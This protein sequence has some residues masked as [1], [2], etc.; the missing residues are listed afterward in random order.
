VRSGL[1]LFSQITLGSVS[2]WQLA[3]LGLFG[4]LESVFPQ[5]LRRDSEL[6]Y[7]NETYGQRL[8][9]RASV[10]LPDNLK[11]RQLRR[12][13]DTEYREAR[14]PLAH[15]FHI[16]PRYNIST[17]KRNV[18]RFLRL[19]EAARLTLVGFLGMDNTALRRLLPEDA[20]GVPAQNTIDSIGR[21]PLAFLDGQKFWRD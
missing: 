6:T 3:M 20:H 1:T 2:S 19:H 5:P 16:A 4:T 11:P 17:T 9:R 10:F 13:I 8:A 21:A 18:A 15:G 7:P 12:F 14:N